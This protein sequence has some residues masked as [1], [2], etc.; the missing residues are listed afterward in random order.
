[1]LVSN[2]TFMIIAIAT[3]Y[4]VTTLVPCKFLVII[5][6][7]Y[8]PTLQEVLKLN[9]DCYTVAYTIDKMLRVS[10]LVS[11]HSIFMVLHYCDII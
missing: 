5:L 8:R 2:I 3:C 1:M 9:H 4:V 10:C 6:I 7:V 11:Q